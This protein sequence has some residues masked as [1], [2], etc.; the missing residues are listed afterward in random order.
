MQKESNVH[1]LEIVSELFPSISNT[2]ADKLEEKKEAEYVSHW[3]KA[4]TSG[5]STCTWEGITANR[6]IDSGRGLSRA[7]SKCVETELT[8]DIPNANN[9]KNGDINEDNWSATWKIWEEESFNKI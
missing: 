8:R 1:D 4:V 6:E 5:L 7:N 2:V 3:I 9:G